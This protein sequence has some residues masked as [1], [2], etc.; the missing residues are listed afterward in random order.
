MDSIVTLDT[1]DH[2]GIVVKDV[3]AA[4]DSWAS[5]L[6]IGDW[7][8]TDGGILK[9]AHARIGSV[10]YELLAPV[11]GQKSLWG[12]FLAARGEGLHHICHTVADVDEA[13][14][15]LVEDGGNVMIST[16]KVFAYVEIGG[17][18]SVILE[19]LKTPAS[20]A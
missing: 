17:P 20:P 16:P 1:F 11:E 18:G 13:V 15:K 19:I 12:D 3:K 10:Q 6:G 8:F 5:K 7:R 14:A 2:V 9:L 4:A